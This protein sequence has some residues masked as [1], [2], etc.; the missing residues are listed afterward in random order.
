M[1]TTR[2]GS[3]PARVLNLRSEFHPFRRAEALHVVNPTGGTLSLHG[4]FLKPLR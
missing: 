4:F 2:K 1:P 3:R